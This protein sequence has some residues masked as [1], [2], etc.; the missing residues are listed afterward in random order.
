M[1]TEEVKGRYFWSASFFNEELEE[2]FY[3]FE[4]DSIIDDPNVW[5]AN[6]LMEDDD[7]RFLFEESEEDEDIDWDLQNELEN[8]ES[9]WV[10]DID[11]R[12]RTFY[13]KKDLD[14]K[15]I[16]KLVKEFFES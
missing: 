4:G 5:L 8:F 10:L 13:S 3:G 9:L 14:F 7:I 2:P 6:Q 11:S 12:T 15:L 1:V 16:S